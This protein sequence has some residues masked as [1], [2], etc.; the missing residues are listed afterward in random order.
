VSQENVETVRRL[1]RVFTRVTLGECLPSSSC[2]RN[3]RTS[4]RNISAISLRP[5]G[6][7]AASPPLDLQAA[8]PT[9]GGVRIC[10][11]TRHQ[12]QGQALLLRPLDVSLSRLRRVSFGPYYDRAVTG[13]Q[14]FFQV[15]VALIPALLFGGAL[16]ERRSGADSAEPP[17][18]SLAILVGVGLLAGVVA[19][20]VAIRGAIDPSVSRLEL[21]YL[22]FVVVAGTIGIAVWTAIPWI[23]KGAVPR[24]TYARLGQRRT[25]V[26]VGL[27]LM[28]ALVV[29]QLSITESLDRASARRALNEASREYLEAN[30]QLNAAERTVT[31]ARAALLSTGARTAPW[32]RRRLEPVLAR[33]LERLDQA[34]NPVLAE[35]VDPDAPKR[36]AELV[37]SR[38][39]AAVKKHNEL[40][41]NLEDALSE[42]NPRVP[43]PH[44]TLVQLAVLRLR[45]AEVERLVAS[46][47]ALRA[48]ERFREACN[49]AQF[50]NCTIS[51]N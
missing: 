38:L 1:N 11:D 34:S 51:T 21:R 12:V 15:A 28:A 44:R 45:A 48:T 17:P 13:S 9:K 5:P 35:N 40:A 2:R 14:A 46:L 49:D 47:N 7:G 4:P 8:R 10:C 19:E 25:L 33:H 37:Q 39:D 23:S 3:H 6:R 41:L 30:R 16:A 20:V 32:I 36:T 31:S 24:Q 29:A 42:G 43:T 22:V 26:L 27:V 50:L 18:R